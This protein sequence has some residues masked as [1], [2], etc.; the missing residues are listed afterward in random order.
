MGPYIQQ[1]LLLLVAPA[2][3]AASIYMILGRMILITHSAQLSP[4]RPTRLTAFF[5]CGDIISF[6]VQATG[7][8]LMAGHKANS[9]SMGKN[10]VL[11]G[12]ALQLAWFVA[13]VV[14]AR[15]W[16]RRVVR[17]M[18]S[19]SADAEHPLLRLSWDRHLKVLY[20]ASGLILVRSV[21]R[22]I[23]YG[24]GNDGYLMRHEVFLY[25]F[26][27]LLMIAVVVVFLIIH[28]S[29]ILGQGKK[30]GSM[31]RLENARGLSAESLRPTK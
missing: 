1:S 24:M 12:L 10:V 2:L 13:F 4:L 8:A 21:F 23:E 9:L 11:V 5:V 27:A 16:Q 29:G 25:L 28:P 7:D 20:T 26:D 22:L 19:M 31:L 30:I 3:F 15:V 6:V 18:V 17:W 14:V